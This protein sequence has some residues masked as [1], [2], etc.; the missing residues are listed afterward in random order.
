LEGGKRPTILGDVLT[1][2]G[3]SDI[4]RPGFR[5]GREII[6]KLKSDFPGDATLQEG[7]EWL[8]GQIAEIEQNHHSAAIAS[9]IWGSTDVPR[10]PSG[11]AC[12]GEC[13][14]RRPHHFPMQRL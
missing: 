12:A 2:L 9:G 6:A 8:D 5:Q 3:D 10:S 7:L 4:D 11:S 1:S 14:R 13:R